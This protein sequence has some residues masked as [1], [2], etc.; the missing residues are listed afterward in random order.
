MSQ[1]LSVL[2]VYN[3]DYSAQLSDAKLASSTCRSYAHELF[4]TRFGI[5]QM[6]LQASVGAP[7]L[8][9]SCSYTNKR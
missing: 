4:L 1:R 9:A 2:A 3:S 7:I 8:R 6:V 5:D